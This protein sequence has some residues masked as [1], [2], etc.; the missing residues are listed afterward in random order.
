MIFKQIINIEMFINLAK[1]SSLA[2]NYIILA[3]NYVV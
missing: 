3:Y 1:F 2:F